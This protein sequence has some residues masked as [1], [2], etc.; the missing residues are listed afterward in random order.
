MRNI[1]FLGE[2]VS[3]DPIMKIFEMERTLIV[4]G[5][6][7]LKERDVRP[8]NIEKQK[9]KPALKIFSPFVITSLQVYSEMKKPGFENVSPLV[10]LLKK[11]HFWWCVHSVR[12]TTEHIFKVF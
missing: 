12:N 1:I 11:M 7:G 10:K 3:F 8:N 2:R 6:R 9:V 4:K 5:I